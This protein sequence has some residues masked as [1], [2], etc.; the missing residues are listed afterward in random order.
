MNGNATDYTGQI[1]SWDQSAYNTITLTSDAL[2]DLKNLSVFK[3]CFVNYQYDYLNNDPTFAAGV[4]LRTSVK[5][6]ETSG[7]SQDPKIDYTLATGGYA[8]NVIGVSSANI[9][10]VIGVA[11][12][13]IDK[14]NG[15]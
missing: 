10:S 15:V 3:I 4:N 14:I 11:T 13:N 9:G 12:A 8:N 6:A 1:N 5:F 2:T 7:T